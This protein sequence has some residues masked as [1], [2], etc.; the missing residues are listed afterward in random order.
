MTASQNVPQEVVSGPTRPLRLQVHRK[1][2]DPERPFW[3]SA[4][5]LASNID[6]C[7]DLPAPSDRVSQQAAQ[8][9]P[10]P[11]SQSIGKI[12]YALPDSSFYQ[13]YDV[14][15]QHD[16]HGRQATSSDSGNGSRSDQLVD[17]PGETAGSASDA[18][19]YIC[20]Q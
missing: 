20:E 12:C 19:D 5:I 7:R 18:E 13:W 3:W 15:Y 8:R 16:Y 17:V 6:S 4:E 10:N 2:P 1:G 14:A 11:S 9:S